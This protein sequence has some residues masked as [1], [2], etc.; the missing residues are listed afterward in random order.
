MC[1]GVCSIKHQLNVLNVP[2]N[3]SNIA[4]GYFMNKLKKPFYVKQYIHY[5]Q[6]LFHSFFLPFFYLSS[7]LY[8][9]AMLSIQ[10]DLQTF[11]TLL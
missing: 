8:K 6:V 1:L 5:V 3:D 2:F 11:V 9:E 10:L 7:V 4:Y